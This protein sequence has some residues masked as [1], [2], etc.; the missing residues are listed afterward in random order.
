MYILSTYVLM[1]VSVCVC[2]CVH[3][4]VHTCVYVHV[5]VHMCVNACMNTFM[6]VCMYI[7]LFNVYPRIIY[8]TCT[9]SH[10]SLIFTISQMLLNNS[11]G[12]A[13]DFLSG[14]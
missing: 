2:V 14:G 6:H 10:R 13:Q 11:Q 12:S 1:H 4:C 9:N 5:Y 7:C 3:V 8:H